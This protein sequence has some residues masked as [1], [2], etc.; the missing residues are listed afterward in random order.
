MRASS[1]RCVRKA[2]TAAQ[3]RIQ[4]HII[5][6]VIGIGS[7]ICRSANVWLA[8]QD[9]SGLVDLNTATTPLLTALL[10]GLGLSSE[11]AG[12]MVS[13]M[14]DYRDADSAG[15]LGTIEPQL[16]PGKDFGP[17]NAPFETPEELDQLPGMTTQLLARLKLLTTVGTQ[18]TGIDF[19][20]A[21]A[22]L[23]V[24][25]GLTRTS[26]AG[27]PFR[28]AAQSRARSILVAVQ[29]NDRTRFVRQAMI[30]QVD[31]PQRPFVATAWGQTQW[32]PALPSQAKNP[33]PC[34]GIDSALPFLPRRSSPG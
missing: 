4:G 7:I 19:G 33:P 16:Y 31:Q 28:S 27:L 25:L 17:K 21:P 15:D 11:Q 13:T 1:T 2:R 8:T 29:L 18:Q 5:G 14:R 9:Q 3:P 20:S 34:S 23:L 30:E 26:V 6:I 22:S 32:P 24:A 12:L 10:E